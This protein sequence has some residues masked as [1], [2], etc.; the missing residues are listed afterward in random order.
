LIW[1]GSFSARTRIERLAGVILYWI[2]LALA[3]TGWFQLRS[4]N[5]QLARIF[6]FYAALVTVAHLPFVMNTRL[7]M[8]FIDPLLA[9]LAGIGILAFLSGGAGGS[10]MTLGNH[11]PGVKIVSASNHMDLP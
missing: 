9:V 3:L 7:R 4:R 2:T 11:V 8:P 1:T 10:K 6:A 5:M